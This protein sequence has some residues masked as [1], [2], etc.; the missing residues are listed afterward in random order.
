[1]RKKI[2]LLFITVWFLFASFS[3]IYNSTNTISEIQNWYVLSDTEKRQKIFGDLYD[4]FVFV[5]H[6]I[7]DGST[8][9][10]F[11]QDVRTHYFGM[12]MLYPT[13]QVDTND[14]KTLMRMVSTKKYEYIATFN[15]A[16][17]NPSYIEIAQFST[18]TAYG[19]VYK[20]K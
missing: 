20:R 18:D 12:Y 19:K 17:R 2:L 3:V 4:F 5:K 13:R 15:Y 14:Q 16:I 9:F 11:S 6:H 7:P 1:M 10:V 8:V